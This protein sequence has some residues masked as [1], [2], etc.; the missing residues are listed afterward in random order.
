MTPQQ[1]PNLENDTSE[2][3]VMQMTPGEELA[4]YR[5]IQAEWLSNIQSGACCFEHKKSGARVLHLRNRD[6]E[7]SLAVA[8]QTP[9]PD[10][11][12]VAH[13]LEHLVFCGSRNYRVKD[14]MAEL[15]K[16]SMATFMNAI[17]C[18]DVTEY[19]FSTRIERD[20]YNLAAAYFDAVFFPLLKEEDF[21]QE[22]CHLVFS[23]DG[24]HTPLKRTG[25]VYNE[26]E[27]AYADLDELI[28]KDTRRLFPE[29]PGGRDSGGD[30]DALPWLEYGTVKD[31]H[32]CYYHPANTL[33]IVSSDLPTEQHLR[34]FADAAFDAFERTSVQVPANVQPQWPSPAYIHRTYPADSHDR[35]SEG[36]VVM[37]WYTNA[38]TDIQA[39]I[40]MH[41]IADLLL[42]HAGAPLRK[43]LVESRLG[44]ELTDSG[45][46]TGAREAYFTV[47]LIGAPPGRAEDI[48]KRVFETLN[49]V[50]QRGFTPEEVEKALNR[51]EIRLRQESLDR[52]LGLVEQVT[53]GWRYQ[54]DPL[55]WLHTDELSRWF[56]GR[57]KKEPDL[58]KR[59]LS[60]LLCRNPHYVVCSYE[61][62]PEFQQR[63]EKTVAAQLEQFRSQQDR[64]YLQKI[65]VN[66]KGESSEIPEA[67]E[68]P[69]EGKVFPRLTKSDVSGR[70]SALETEM[71]RE[72]NTDLLLTR[73]S[74][75]GLNFV[76]LCSDL[77]HLD[78]ELLDWLP[79]YCDVCRLAGAG[80]LDYAAMS[81][82]EAA[83]GHNLAVWPGITAP[84]AAPADVQPLFLMNGM[85]LDGNLNGMLEVMAQR[86]FETDL[87][88]R[89]RVARIVEQRFAVCREQLVAEAPDGLPLRAGRGQ[90]AFYH[91]ADRLN[92][93]SQY[94]FMR[95]VAEMVESSEGIEKVIC[96]LARIRD[97]IR[98]QGI[99]TISFAGTERGE[100]KIRADRARFQSGSRVQGKGG[101]K[102]F[103]GE[104]V[105]NE[106][107]AYPVG[108]NYVTMTWPCVAPK[109]E[110]APVFTLIGHELSTGTLWE[111]VRLKGG[112][113]GV[114]ASYHASACLFVVSSTEDPQIVRTLETFRNVP[115]Y[116]KSRV[117]AY[118]QETF[119]QVILGAAKGIDIPARGRDAAGRALE[120]HL[121]GVTREMRQDF[122]ERILEV[123]PSQVAESCERWLQQGLYQASTAVFGDQSALQ[124]ANA[125]LEAANI[126]LETFEWQKSRTGTYGYG[127]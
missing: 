63:R 104:E 50:A 44:Q 28:E 122:L 100:K 94:L 82:R 46:D 31:F 93:V 95:Q 108:V 125:E 71:E 106:G 33:T 26:M 80:G 64:A 118:E 27:G 24:I 55:Y 124:Q 39:V 51:Y 116:L 59:Y 11:T 81:E 114:N 67:P 75:N 115:T 84:V 4:G 69:G 10:N 109:S 18:Q 121:R 6:P 76:F 20:F 78:D 111:D 42:G 87:T 68:K 96:A 16:S 62:D 126:H 89:E 101:A 86:C 61:P 120:F 49:E 13:V 79:L 119:E 2:V 123:T 37:S 66:P 21:R 73:T 25:I 15:E 5:L 32:T 127:G 56:R 29:S 17:T 23:G 57:L 35:A 36:A 112:A 58:L 43:A 77:Q 54:Q 102:S 40:A 38:V 34:F 83:V 85:T 103:S 72:D 110:E 52:P 30:P 45:Y 7:K 8:V 3:D 19:V 99:T 48:Q 98:E 117:A 113:Y 90:S 9:P 107:I 47:G 74:C 41:L 60:R 12:G 65:L 97:F 92:W 70:V 14:I 91:L 53:H 105:V 88:D 22:A 1:E